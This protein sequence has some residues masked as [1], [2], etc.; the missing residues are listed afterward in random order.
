M[1][2]DTDSHVYQQSKDVADYLFGHQLCGWY[3]GTRCQRNIVNG[4]VKDPDYLVL[5]FLSSYLQRHNSDFLRSSC[6]P[7]TVEPNQ[8]IAIGHAGKYQF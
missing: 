1:I 4:Q 3:S 5:F 8:R 2:P 7:K 6:V